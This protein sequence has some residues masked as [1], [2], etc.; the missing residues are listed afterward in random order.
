ML[1]SIRIVHPA[2]AR[3]QS[4]I[5][6]EKPLGEQQIE[7]VEARDELAR[8][9]ARA[10]KPIGS[11][12]ARE[13]LPRLAVACKVEQPPL[14]AKLDLAELVVLSPISLSREL[15]PDEGGNQAGSA[16][17]RERGGWST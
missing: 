17:E 4:P 1:G 14:L 3:L 5:A 13:V 15:V 6:R 12:P 11:P 2:C 16:V 10:R 7:W 8:P 9:H